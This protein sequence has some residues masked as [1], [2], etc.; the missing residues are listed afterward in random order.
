M[1]KKRAAESYSFFEK[2]LERS[3]AI[4]LVPKKLGNIPEMAVLLGLISPKFYKIYN[5]CEGKK[6][7]EIASALNID[8]KEIVQDIDK[9]IKNKMVEI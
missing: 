1:K 5:L 4:N 3:D 6:I 8:T 7:S 9:L 2:S